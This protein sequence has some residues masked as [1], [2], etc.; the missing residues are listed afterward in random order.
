MRFLGIYITE[1]LKWCV[2]VCSLCSSLSMLSYIMKLLQAVLSPYTLRSIYFAYFQSCSRHGIIFWGRDSESKTAFKVQKRVI[3][4]I[5]SANKCKSCR[6]NSKDYRILTVTS[7][8]ILEVFC[9]IKRYKEN[10]EQNWSIHGHNLRSKLNFHVEFYNTV[11][12]QKNVVNM[13]IKF[14]N[15]EPVSVK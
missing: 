11:L 2:H 13:G 8:Y 5:S 10:L 1:N 7:L 6:L 12:L 3:W 15:K 9:Y 4:I 14:Y